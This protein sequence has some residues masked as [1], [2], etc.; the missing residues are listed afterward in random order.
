MGLNY[1]VRWWGVMENVDNPDEVCCCYRFPRDR[2][3]EFVLN[4]TESIP[5]LGEMAG[6]QVNTLNV[7]YVNIEFETMYN[8][9][10]TLKKMKSLVY[11]HNREIN[12]ISTYF[13][14]LNGLYYYGNLNTLVK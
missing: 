4:F 12:G 14:S 8:E 6:I 9:P 13:P 2:W 1:D 10:E 11:L 5:M 7:K 3:F